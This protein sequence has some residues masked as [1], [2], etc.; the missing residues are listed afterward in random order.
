MRAGDV[1]QFKPMHPLGGKIGIVTYVDTVSFSGHFTSSSWYFH[2]S[3]RSMVEPAP[4]SD[5]QRAIVGA[6][7]AAEALR[8][9]K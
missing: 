9:M 2:R 5:A 8:R 4:L 7:I 6:A 1:V 3:S